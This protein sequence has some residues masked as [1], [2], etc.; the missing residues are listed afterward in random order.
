M[1][2]EYIVIK[3]IRNISWSFVKQ[4]YNKVGNSGDVKLSKW[5]LQIGN[6]RNHWLARSTSHLDKHIEIES[7]GRLRTKLYNRRDDFYF[8]IVNFSVICS[9]I[10]AAP[11]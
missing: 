3:Y 7:E 2:A 10:P 6:T 5:L 9:N 11:A 4:I 1:N 8:P